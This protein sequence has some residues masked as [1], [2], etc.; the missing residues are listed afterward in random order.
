MD[1]F[2]INMGFWCYEIIENDFFSKKIYFFYLD[3]DVLFEYHRAVV[4]FGWAI[5]PVRSEV[6]LP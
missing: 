3:R 1:H 4:P 6:C 5:R 2:T